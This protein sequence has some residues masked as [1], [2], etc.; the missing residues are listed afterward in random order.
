MK[1]INDPEKINES[2]L[3]VTLQKWVHTVMIFVVKASTN[4]SSLEVNLARV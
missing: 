1:N 4:G 3:K 2:I